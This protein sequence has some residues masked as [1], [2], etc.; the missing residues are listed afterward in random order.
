MGLPRDAGEIDHLRFFTA[1][2]W[3]FLFYDKKK[4]KEFLEISLPPL[5]DFI[6]F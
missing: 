5:F 4:N 2:F 1:Y 3:K 6:D